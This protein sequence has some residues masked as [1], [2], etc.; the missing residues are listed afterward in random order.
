MTLTPMIKELPASDSI[1]KLTL[2]AGEAAKYTR[3]SG[4]WWR[5]HGNRDWKLVPNVF[6]DRASEDAEKNLALRFTAKAATRHTKCP[7][8]TDIPGWLF[9][10][11]HYGLPTRLLDWTETILIAA[12][13]AATDRPDQDG[14]IWGLLPFH[15]N[16][17]LLG[18]ASV[19]LPGSDIVQPLFGAAVGRNKIDSDQAVAVFPI[20]TEPRM[21]MQHAAFTIHSS[22]KPLEEFPRAETFLLRSVVPASAKAALVRDLRSLGI[23]RSTAFP[24]LH[25]L[26]L[27]LKETLTEISD[28]DA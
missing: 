13:F 21:Q 24:D 1:G 25:N 2:L 8:H 9:L 3:G 4:V 27:D 20:E 23:R 11:Q 26:A 16:K 15:M 22:S 10:M 17:E 7:L 12:Y 18:E 6:R 5:G 28:P 19:P 14:A